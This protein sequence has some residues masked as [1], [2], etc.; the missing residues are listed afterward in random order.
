MF[1]TLKS[2]I[3]K[4]V[5]RDQIKRELPNDFEPE[6]Y[7]QLHPDIQQARVDP[8][9]HYVFHGKKTMRRYRNYRKGDNVSVPSDLPSDFDPGV[10]L[11]IHKDLE[12]LD[13]FEHY[14][15][16]GRS[17][18]R[19]YRSPLYT[20]SPDLHAP[21]VSANGL[22][23]EFDFFL[24][25]KANADL[26]IAGVD[27]AK[28]FLEIGQYEGRPLRPAIKPI[29]RNFDPDEFI[30]TRPSRLLH[31]MKPRADGSYYWPLSTFHYRA[32]DHDKMYR[33]WAIIS[34]LY[35]K[36]H[37]IEIDAMN[38]PL[39]VRADAAVSH[40]T[41]MSEEKI[42]ASAPHLRGVFNLN[43][44]ALIDQFDLSSIS[45]NSQDFLILNNAL[46]FYQNPIVMIRDSS[47]IL[48]RGGCVF[49]SVPDHRY[50]VDF[51]RRVTSLNHL[52]EDYKVG[53]QVSRHMHYLEFVELVIGEAANRHAVAGRLDHETYPIHFHCWT[54]HTFVSFL[55]DVLGQLELP[56]ELELI[57][58][59]EIETICILRRT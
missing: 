39:P 10:Y 48:R 45:P 41:T 24:F 44:A 21:A 40:L 34:H 33:N 1:A 7:L 14:R 6:L 11:S 46:P 29:P 16:Y 4:W 2:A 8:V 35:L 37:G 52:W 43:P 47:Q 15:R 56:L 36:G 57:A 32:C 51:R 12:S 28:H 53:P 49:V 55:L 42:L 31:P 17:E 26:A 3:T 19:F 59:N 22:P 38:A 50:G 9:L 30:N 54:H 18:G 20:S 25:L 5:H 27:P 23:F 13:P 58:R